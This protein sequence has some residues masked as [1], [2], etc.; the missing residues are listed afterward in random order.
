[1]HFHNYLHVGVN[2]IHSYY[3][4]QYLWR[5]YLAMLCQTTK[6]PYSIL[7]GITKQDQQILSWISQASHCKTNEDKHLHMLHNGY[8]GDVAIGQSKM[9]YEYLGQIE[10]G[11]LDFVGRWKQNWKQR[12]EGMSSSRVMNKCTIVRCSSYIWPYIETGS[13]MYRLQME[14]A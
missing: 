7:N 8:S 6:L 5:F 11:A 4:M 3:T 9:K 1:M 13:I 2:P 10:A 12:L 14:N